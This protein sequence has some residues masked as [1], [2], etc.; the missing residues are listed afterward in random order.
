MLRT[1]QQYKDGLKDGREVW[2]DGERVKDITTH[3]H[4]KQIGRAHV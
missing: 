2:M 1:G 4:F 3:A